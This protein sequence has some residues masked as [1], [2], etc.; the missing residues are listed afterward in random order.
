MC[1]NAEVSLQSF[2]LGLIGIIVGGI[3]GVS[4]P[5]LFFFSTIVCMQF[6]EFIVWT[7]LQ[8]KNI[9]FITSIFASFLLQL[10]PIASILT[11]YPQSIT[12]SLLSI[13]IL[14]LIV[15]NYIVWFSINEPLKTHFDMYPGKNG[16]LVWNWIKKDKFT[17]ISIFGYSIFLFLPLIMMKRWSFVIYGLITLLVSLYTFGKTNTWGSMWCW[18]IDL[19]IIFIGAHILWLNIIKKLKS[20]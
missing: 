2:V 14:L 13:Y 5:L 16:H 9:R 1:W 6:F 12:Y 20:N 17:Y 7:Y 19:S 15:H 10:Q 8:N 11:L 4:F 3:Y 18:M